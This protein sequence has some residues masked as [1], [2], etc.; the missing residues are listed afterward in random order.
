VVHEEN[1]LNREVNAKEKE[2]G[3]VYKQKKEN[4]KEE[5]QELRAQVDAA[6]LK[7]KDVKP[8]RKEKEAELQKKLNA[9][10]NIVHESV[11][12]SKDEVRVLQICQCLLTHCR[13]LLQ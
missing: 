6:N 13:M 9:V 8:R 3:L 12:V 2:I 7:L 4:A 11:P 1:E 5:V 10:G